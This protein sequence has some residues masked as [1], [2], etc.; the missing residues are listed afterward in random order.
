MEELYTVQEVFEIIMTQHWDMAAC[1]CFICTN[2]RRWGYRPRGIYQDYT[3]RKY[4]KVTVTNA[5]V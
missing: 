3:G 5:E 4:P 1:P 2:G